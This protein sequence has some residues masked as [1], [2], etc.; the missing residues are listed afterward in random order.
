MGLVVDIAG[1][2]FGILTVTRFHGLNKRMKSMW[3]CVCDCGKEKFFAGDNLK[4]GNTTSCGCTKYAKNTK[5]GK[6]KSLEYRSWVSMIGRCS[7][8][9]GKSYKD[10]GGR[11]IIICTRW[12]QSFESFLEDMGNKPSAEYSIDRIDT[13][14]NYEPSNCKWSTRSEQ[15]RNK[16]ISKR[17]TTGYPGVMWNKREG[18]WRAKITVDDK[19]IHVGVFN[20]ISEA[21]EA[22]K[23]AEIK[24]W[25][26]SSI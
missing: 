10:Y 2:R 13:N 1:K 20:T 19:N 5:H 7:N 4:K 15:E 16:R 23:Q 17:S 9:K 3:Q 25:N 12:L 26:K 24:Y 6:S 21:I 22:R 18:R 11:G 8:D 14:G